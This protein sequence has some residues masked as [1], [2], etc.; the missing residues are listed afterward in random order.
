[1]TSESASDVVFQYLPQEKYTLY[2]NVN[3][4]RDLMVVG[5]ITTCAISGYHH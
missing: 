5:C 2:I 4:C 1:M 3:G